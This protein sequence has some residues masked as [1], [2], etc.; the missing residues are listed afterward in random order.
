MASRHG[1]P[2]GVFSSPNGRRGD[3]EPA[4]ADVP[5]ALHASYTREEILAALD[6]T[7]QGR[8]PSTMRE[9]VAWC[10]AVNADAFLITLKKSDTDYS[11]TTMYR[12]FALSPEL[13]HWESQSTTSSSSPTGQ[14]YLHHRTNGSHILL[15]VREAKTNSLGTSPYLFLGPADYVAH[16]GERPIAITWRLRRPMPMEMFIA[17]RAAVA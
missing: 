10:P 11:P 1:R 8:V 2:V 15:F 16:E 17:S 4:L 12:D 5:L 3:V 13:F 7:S 6:W 9:G 14:R